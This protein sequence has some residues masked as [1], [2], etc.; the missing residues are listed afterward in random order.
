MLIAGELCTDFKDEAKP[1]MGAS[2]DQATNNCAKGL[3]CD[4]L[5]KCAKAVGDEC[6]DATVCIMGSFCTEEKKCAACVVG[7][8]K[9]DSAATCTKCLPGYIEVP[10]NGKCTPIENCPTGC[11][12]C[13]PDVS[14]DAE[15][16]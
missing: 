12:T 10:E 5:N 9:C 2:C 8:N 1:G 13:T 3:S 7:C 14:A 6:D 15:A 16:D 11:A 4:G